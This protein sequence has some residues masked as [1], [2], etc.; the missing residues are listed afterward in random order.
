LHIYI[1]ALKWNKC[2]EFFTLPPFSTILFHTSNKKFRINFEQLCSIIYVIP[3]SMWKVRPRP[4][5]IL[6]FC[7][8]P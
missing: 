5:S 4:K 1:N 3:G 6:Y 7:T 2:V 8:F